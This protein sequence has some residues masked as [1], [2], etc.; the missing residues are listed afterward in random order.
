MA[1]TALEFFLKPQL[2]EESWKYFR[3]VQTKDTKYTPFIDADDPPAIWLNTR[4]MQEFKPKL[5]PFYYDETRFDSYLE[6]LGITYPT[7]RQ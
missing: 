3:E 7:V 1:R 5:E 2:V 6:Q 4:I